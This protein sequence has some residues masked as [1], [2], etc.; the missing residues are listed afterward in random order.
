M[1]NGATGRSEPLT[2]LAEDR[3]EWWSAD[4]RG[5]APR[6]RR[7]PRSRPGSERRGRASTMAPPP[8][9]PRS[10]PR[11]R[12]RLRY[13]DASDGEASP[14]EERRRERRAPAASPAQP[15]ARGR[16]PPPRSRTPS[17]LSLIHI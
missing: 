4:Q 13:D 1:G 9:P 7:P 2:P 8:E 5:S 14:D 17:G 3:E 16:P 15:P 10:A 11:A 12:R 6:D